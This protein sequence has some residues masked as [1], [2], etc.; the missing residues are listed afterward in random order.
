LDEAITAY[1][2]ALA[3]QSRDRAPLDRAFSQTNLGAALVILG[4]RKKG[5]VQLDEAVAILHE[6][7]TARTREDTPFLWAETQEKL[8][9]AHFALFDKSGDPNHRAAA[10]DAIGGA[11]D[12]YRRVSAAFYIE[13]ATRLRDKILAATF[14]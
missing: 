3:E 1:H 2:D 13:K 5:T 10:L 7:L 11:L 9:S 6:A 4:Q 14:R 8:A 12:E